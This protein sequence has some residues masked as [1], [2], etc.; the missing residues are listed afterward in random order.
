MKRLVLFLMMGLLFIPSFQAQTVSGPK[1]KPAKPATTTRSTPAPP[2]KKTIMLSVNGYTEEFTLPE[3]PYEGKTVVLDVT[4]NASSYNLS[5]TPYWCSVDEKTDG[6]FSLRVSAN[7]SSS[8]SAS[9]TVT[10]EDKTVTFHLSQSGFEPSLTV[11][12]LTSVSSSYSASSGTMYYSV[13]AN[14]DYTVSLLPSWCSVENKTS[15]GFTIRYTANNSSSSRSDYFK[16]SNGTK[17]VR[18]DVTQA[19]GYTETPLSRGYWRS[20]VA[21]RKYVSNRRTYNDGSVY[22]GM[23]NNYGGRHGFGAYF[24]NDG[25]IYL[26]LWENGDMHVA[27]IYIIGTPETH[28]ILNCSGAIYYVG[29]YDHDKKSGTGECYDKYGNALYRGNFRDNKPTAY[30]TSTPSTS[31]Q[32]D[33]FQCI[34][35]TSG[36]F[37]LGETE[38]GNRAGLGVYFWSNGAWWIGFWA[39]DTRDG[40]GMYVDA[41]GRWDYG[42]WK[43]D[44]KIGTTTKNT[45]SNNNDAAYQ[46]GYELGRALFNAFSK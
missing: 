5:E 38:N 9:I 16:V 4:T 45:S 27:G 26:G 40:W 29:Q 44:T 3:I 10:A 33:K 31:L 12:G 8:R 14:A 24:F 18:I 1:K 30:Y 46:L 6:H 21:S 36:D 7:S 20:K 13:N 22:V 39:N 19:A 42:Q 37:Y 23:T 25:G 15:S 32:S 28:S 35:Y 41:S 11:N 43:G 2:K 34:D 17:S